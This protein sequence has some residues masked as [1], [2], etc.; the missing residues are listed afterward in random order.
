[1]VYVYTFLQGVRVTKHYRFDIGIRRRHGDKLQLVIS[2]R[3]IRNHESTVRLDGRRADECVEQRACAIHCTEY[4]PNVCECG[5]R[6]QLIFESQ[7]ERKIEPRAEC[8]DDAVCIVIDVQR[9]FSSKRCNRISRCVCLQDV[10]SWCDIP[11]LKTSIGLHRCIRTEA[12]E[13]TA[14]GLPRT[15]GDECPRR[16][17]CG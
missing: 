7:P 8:D 15:Q 10:R 4:R 9:L 16:R 2:C 11:N 1:M 6:R 5:R 17:I 14:G 13:R 3:Y 12:D